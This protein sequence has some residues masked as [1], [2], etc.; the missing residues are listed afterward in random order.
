MLSLGGS[1]LLR[2]VEEV[3]SLLLHL[4]WLLVANMTLRTGPGGNGQSLAFLAY[5]KGKFR[6]AHGPSQIVSLNRGK[7][8][9]EALFPH[10]TPDG[11]THGHCLMHA[12][13]P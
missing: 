10:C 13:E 3:Y 7:I 1:P 8:Q 12:H 9:E 6:N 2:Y 11:H 5:P 4:S